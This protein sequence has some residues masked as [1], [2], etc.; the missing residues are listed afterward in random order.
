MGAKGAV[1]ILY[2]RQLKA[3]PAEDRERKR[4]Q[5]ED[6]F[7]Q[8]F[9]SPFVAASSGHIDDVIY[10]RETRTRVIA[11]L[12]YLKDKQPVTQPKKHGNIPL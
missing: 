12:D 5:L 2:A 3:T 6:E 8:E 11:A 1:S 9:N 7:Q 10:P 4:Q